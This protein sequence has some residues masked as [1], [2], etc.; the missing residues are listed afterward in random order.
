MPLPWSPH[1]LLTKLRSAGGL[2][3][4]TLEGRVSSGH[5]IGGRTACCTQTGHSPTSLQ[6]QTKIFND[7]IDLIDFH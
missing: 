3:A 4:I 1:Q 2:K 6:M 7:F 5:K